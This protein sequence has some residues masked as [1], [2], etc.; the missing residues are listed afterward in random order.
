MPQRIL[1][2]INDTSSK[3]VLV[4][5]DANNS[6]I[7][8]ATV[9]FRDPARQDSINSGCRIDGLAVYRGSNEITYIR[10]DG[11]NITNDGIIQVN[12]EI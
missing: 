3:T 7:T 4:T 10:H 2:N 12:P 11:F 9:T 6:H 5:V 1:V 8:T